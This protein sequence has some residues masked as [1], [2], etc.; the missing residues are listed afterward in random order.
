MSQIL[1]VDGDIYDR[2]TMLARQLTALC[3]L[4]SVARDCFDGMADHSR[5]DLLQLKCDLSHDLSKT[6]T[7][8]HR[9]VSPRQ[10]GG[11][12]G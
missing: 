4:L 1:R 10:A 11:E 9:S 7:E 5:D 2:A 12:R 3:L 6:L 8:M